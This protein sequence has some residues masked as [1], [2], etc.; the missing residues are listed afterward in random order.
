MHSPTPPASAPVAGPAAD[1]FSV[2]EVL[3]AAAL[4]LMVTI[5]IIPMFTRSMQ[6]NVQGSQATKVSNMAKSR[7]EELQQFT[8]NSPEL[9]VP[10]GATELV[11]Q[12]FFSNAQHV[13]LDTLPA[14]DTA[15]F[16]RTTRIREFSITAV[17]PAETA[18]IGLPEFEDSEALVGGGDASLIHLKEIEV[19]LESPEQLGALGPGKKLRLR[20]YKTF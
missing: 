16:V 14:G 5:G 3:I 10:A 4:L 6:N 11:S 20:A 9:L 13:W 8:F 15:E 1:G 19:L 7:M 2:V 18:I 17:S 12:Q